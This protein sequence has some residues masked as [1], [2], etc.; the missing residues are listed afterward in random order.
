MRTYTYTYQD[1]QGLRHE[2]EIRATDKDSAYTELRGKGI[3]PMKV[4]EKIVPVVKKGIRG[5]RKRD[6][7]A[8]V[9]V[10]V[11][12][13]I[14]ASVYCFGLGRKS[15]ETESQT[16]REEVEVGLPRHIVAMPSDDV[17][18]EA[19]PNDSLRLLAK[20]AVPGAVVEEEGELIETEVFAPIANLDSDSQDV[21]ELKQIVIGMVQDARR[22]SANPD[23]MKRYYEFLKERQAMERL[24]FADTLRRIAQKEISHDEGN[25]ILRGM[26]LQNEVKIP[27]FPPLRNH[28][29]L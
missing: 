20:Y 12:V 1:A 5:L 9:V 21:A 6:I 29:D 28:R 17:L 19:F 24:R 13:A 25:A 15:G 8:I 10:G 23:G 16:L 2:G 11:V 7:T 3:R 14:A 27:A 22:Y 26:G 4:V 18:A